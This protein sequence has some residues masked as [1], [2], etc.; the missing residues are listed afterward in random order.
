MKQ[1]TIASVLFIFSGGMLLGAD[2]VTQAPLVLRNHDMDNFEEMEFL[3]DGKLIDYEY[4]LVELYLPLRHRSPS[5]LVEAFLSVGSLKWKVD[6]GK[7]LI[8]RKAARFQMEY[9]KDN[10]RFYMF[11]HTYTAEGH[12]I[13]FDTL[14]R[15]C[16]DSALLLGSAKVNAPGKSAPRNGLTFR[17]LHMATPEGFVEYEFFP[18]GTLIAYYDMEGIPEIHGGVMDS[19]QTIFKAELIPWRKTNGHIVVDHGRLGE[20]VFNVDKGSKTIASAKGT[21]T[22]VKHLEFIAKLYAYCERPLPK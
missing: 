12:V 14:W 16:G 9:E 20:E 11:E 15:Y 8:G 4:S 21:W 17:F 13:F 2:P 5:G 18:G 22:S 6:G 19:T 1:K 10:D 7:L 3:P